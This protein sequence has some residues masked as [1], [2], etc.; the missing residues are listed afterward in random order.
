MSLANGNRKDALE[1]L[2]RAIDTGAFLLNSYAWAKAI[3]VRMEKE[4]G[5]PSW[6]LNADRRD[7]ATATR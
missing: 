3:R 1:H 7:G 4:E 6:L 2:H 5:W